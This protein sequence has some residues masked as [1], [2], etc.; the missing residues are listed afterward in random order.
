MTRVIDLDSQCTQAL[1]ADA[2]GLN[3]STVSRLLSEGVLDQSG[4]F[5]GWLTDYCDRL[6]EMAAGRLGSSGT[7]GLDLVQERAALAR[8]QRISQ[9]LKNAVARG[10]YAPIAV[11][12]DVLGQASS[13]VVDRLDQVEGS[14]RKAC[15]EISDD[16]MLTV[17]GA[18]TSARNEW[19]RATNS[20]IETSM[21][22]REQDDETA[23]GP[24]ND[25]DIT[26]QFSQQH[27]P[28]DSL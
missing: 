10:E 14:L 3:P 19:V 8:E 7:G 5:S 24:L 13:A 12:A 17:L 4:T 2:M 11:L 25:F 20:L 22:D 21:D 15:P 26:A 9:E 6:R 1:F 28:K 23:D 16:V 18:L 27:T